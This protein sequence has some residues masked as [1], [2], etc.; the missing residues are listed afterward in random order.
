MS[1]L[2]SFWR[3]LRVSIVETST[4]TGGDG[5]KYTIFHVHVESTYGTFEVLRRYRQFD[6]LNA[7]LIQEASEMNLPPFPKKRALGN[8]AT[9]FVEER[10][11]ALE[12]YLRGVLNIDGVMR[13]EPLVRF[14]ELSL[15]LQMAAMAAK[16]RIKN[17]AVEVRR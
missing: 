3:S 12:D 15:P 13:L 5:N 10:K 1:E 16:I 9:E 14:L 2:E 11:L 4:R 17:D 8:L 7:E 6:A